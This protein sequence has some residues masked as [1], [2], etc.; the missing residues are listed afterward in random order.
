MDP[1]ISRVGELR[2]RKQ[3]LDSTVRR[4]EANVANL[5]R[6]LDDREDPALRQRLEV[7]LAELERAQ[8]ELERVTDELEGA[9]LEA[10]ERAESV[11]ELERLV[12][13]FTDVAAKAPELATVLN[14]M[15][16]MVGALATARRLE[17]N[18]P[19][20]T[21]PR[22]LVASLTQAL[23]LLAETLSR[24]GPQQTLRER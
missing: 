2:R 17:R 13:S 19:D 6:L 12:D 20:L 9:E 11:D 3:D 7:V 1:L 18:Q 5:E 16:A 10:R 14:A 23:M 8:P 21:E 22:E 4:L 15:R 24:V